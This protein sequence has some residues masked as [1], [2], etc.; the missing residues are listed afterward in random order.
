M[1]LSVASFH[2][3]P[4]Y[5][6]AG[7]VLTNPLDQTILVDSGELLAGNYLVAVSVASSGLSKYSVKVLST[8]LVTRYSQLR[9]VPEAGNDDFQIGNKITLY[10][11]DRIRI[12]LE[13]VVAG[14]GS[15]Q[16]SLYFMEVG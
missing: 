12:I 15:I 11:G 14:G 8:G 16:A 1:G 7:S 13:G 10:G 6:I 2:H 9:Y 5:W 4:G 3:G